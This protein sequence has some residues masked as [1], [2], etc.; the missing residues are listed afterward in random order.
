[1]RFVR[2]PHGVVILAAYALGGTALLVG[3]PNAA[4]P[5]WSHEPVP[6]SAPIAA[7]MLPTAMLVTD[8][9]LRGLCLRHP[10]DTQDAADDLAINDAIMLRFLLFVLGVHVMVLLGMEGVLQGRMWAGQV[11]PV[12]LG[13]TMISI[14][15]L[16]P[17]TRP[18][19]AIGIRTRRMLLDRAL[20]MRT[21][22]STGYLLVI[23][24]IIIVLSALAVP[25]PVGPG[26]ILLVGPGILI[27]TCLIVWH[28]RRSA[29]H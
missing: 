23:C 10:V 16:L 17:R 4:V 9:L 19:L 20:W 21:H 27:A 1:M 29:H 14:G 13:L 3:F 5:A 15:N 12:M 7:F 2:S 6:W 24:G 22:R 28:G 26:M 8:W 11:V 18:N 25:S